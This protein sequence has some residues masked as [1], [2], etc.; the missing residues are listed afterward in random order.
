MLSC[1]FAPWSLITC[2]YFFFLLN[3]KLSWLH[4]NRFLSSGLELC[5]CSH[6]KTCFL[7]SYCLNEIGDS[8]LTHLAHQNITLV[9]TSSWLGPPLL[10]FFLCIPCTNILSFSS[11][12]LV[13]AE[14]GSLSHS[15]GITVHLHF[16]KQLLDSEPC[17][18]HFR[19]VLL[20]CQV[21][22]PVL[23]KII[24]ISWNLE[25]RTT[26][27]LLGNLWMPRKLSR[28]TDLGPQ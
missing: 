8:I 24:L 19:G 25:F 12:I 16:D 11:V 6:F 10:R 3:P 5:L 18:K 7:G 9:C 13:S 23:E 21:I 28:N 17:A 26:Q 22:I 14:R 15:S 1:L 2:L 27:A 4:F 20:F